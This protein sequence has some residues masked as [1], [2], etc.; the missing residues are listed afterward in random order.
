M[1]MVDRLAVPDGNDPRAAVLIAHEGPGLDDIQL[2]R[3]DRL[4]EL[5]FEVFALDYHGGGRYFTDRAEMMARLG[6]LGADPDR[7]TRIATAGLDVYPGAIGR[8]NRMICVAV[9]GSAADS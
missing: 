4:A 6:E 2:A 1:R 3:A 7:T 9:V 5:G 8:M